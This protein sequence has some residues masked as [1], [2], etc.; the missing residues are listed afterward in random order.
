MDLCLFFICIVTTLFENVIIPIGYVHSSS[1]TVV[2]VVK[3]SPIIHSSSSSISTST[4]VDSVSISH[5]SRPHNSDSHTPTTDNPTNIL[6]LQVYEHEHYD[7][8][9]HMW[10]SGTQSPYP[11]TQKDDPPTATATVTAIQNSQTR[12]FHKLHTYDRIQEQLQQH[13]K[14]YIHSTKLHHQ[15]QEDVHES[16]SST[17]WKIHRWLSISSLYPN[18]DEEEEDKQ[19]F[20]LTPHTSS[21]SSSF[22]VIP[23]SI[24]TSSPYDIPPPI[25][26]TFSS[27]WKIDLRGTLRD[28]YGWYYWIEYYHYNTHHTDENHTTFT[29]QEQQQVQDDYIHH[30]PTGR[31]ISLPRRR[32]RWIRTL[33]KIQVEPESTTK[34]TTTT[35]TTVYHDKQLQSSTISTPPTSITAT[36]TPSVFSSTHHFT[37]TSSY[38]DSSLFSLIKQTTKQIQDSFNFKGYGLSFYK[39]A[40]WN[41][42]YPRL[43]PTSTISSFSKQQHPYIHS[44]GIA[45]RLPLSSHFSFLEEKP[46]IP[47]LSSSVAYHMDVSS[48]TYRISF[49]LSM[50]IPTAILYSVILFF[51]EYIQWCL[52]VGI[53]ILS[54]SILFFPFRYI[55]IVNRKNKVILDSTTIVDHHSLSLERSTSSSSISSSDMRSISSQAVSSAA[56]KTTL[57]DIDSTDES[58]HRIKNTHGQEE[59]EEKDESDDSES[60]EDLQESI[61]SIQESTKG[62]HFTKSSTFLYH[63][64]ILPIPP[65]LRAPIYARGIVDRVGLTL[66]WRYHSIKGY[67]KKWSWFHMYLPTLHYWVTALNKVEQM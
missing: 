28:D 40:L 66:S 59:E 56:S 3:K 52:H 60:E 42:I 55:M 30:H 8:T 64:M 62:H 39:N 46:Y 35:T 11:H 48:Q 15:Q 22:I 33:Q 32:R 18:N 25:G 20:I 37:S 23:I 34:T 49:N 12:M 29:T 5:M 65:T 19:D 57:D 41:N 36:S 53:V 47:L 58:I 21:S 67:E 26:Y 38:Y 27:E 2:G 17:F 1:S 9:R 54:Q 13:Y 44:Y 51:M 43:F 7:T 61:H 24:F 10:L 6:Q 31:W 45:I 4:D 16:F 63:G 50:S 14:K